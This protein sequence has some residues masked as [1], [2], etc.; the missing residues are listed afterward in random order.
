MSEIKAVHNYEVKDTGS[1]HM[2]FKDGNL[3]LCPF[4]PPF[5]A[6]SKS[7]MS[8]ELQRFP[9]STRC[10][11]AEVAEDGEEMVYVISCCGVPKVIK[12]NPQK[13]QVANP[14]IIT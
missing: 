13:P 1:E 10:P 9:C 14:L 2:L 8:A 6:P 11:L 4:P 5:L 12:V 3:T 7:G